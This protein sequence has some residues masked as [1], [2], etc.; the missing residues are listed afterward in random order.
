[1]VAAVVHYT[2]PQYAEAVMGMLTA[3]IVYVVVDFAFGHVLSHRPAEQEEHA[4]A[5]AVE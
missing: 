4:L 2:A 3:G 5:A 1:V